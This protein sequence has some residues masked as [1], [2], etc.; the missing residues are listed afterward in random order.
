MNTKK[1]ASENA[2]NESGI[3]GMAIKAPKGARLY[4]L[5]FKVWGYYCINNPAGE[6]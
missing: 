4:S 5:P 2:R 3:D 6:I 1:F